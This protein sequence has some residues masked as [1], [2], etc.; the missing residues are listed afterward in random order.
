MHHRSI[1]AGSVVLCLLCS[2]GLEAQQSDSSVSNN[3]NLPASSQSAAGTVPG[4]IK[5]TGAVKDLTGKV[6]TGVAGLTFSLYELPEG[7]SPLWVETQSLPLD[8]L[9]R[10]AAL[11]GA[12]SPGGLPLDLF[13]T[14]KALWV[15]VQAQLPGAVEQP[16]VLLV[17]VPY[18]LKAADAD[19]LGGKPAS[20]FATVEDQPFSA[21]ALGTVP[22]G[23]SSAQ[24]STRSGQTVASATS[25]SCASVTSD[26]AATAN[27]LAKFVSHCQIENSAVSESGGNV[28]VT[29]NLGLPGTT[30]RGAGVIKLGGAP[31]IHECCNNSGYSNTFI[32]LGAGNFSGT[33]TYNTGSG[34]HAL[35]ANTNGKFN[36]ASGFYALSSNTTGTDNTANGGD[37]LGYNTTG[38]GNTASGRD[39][40]GRN[41][42]GNFNTAS[43]YG[44]LSL[45]TTGDRNTASGY[46]ALWL[47]T[48]GNQN[49]ASG[50]QALSANTTGNHNTGSGYQ[51]LYANTTGGYNT[52]SGYQA[53]Y[54][55]TKGYWNTASGDW[56]LYSNTTGFGNTASGVAALQANTTGYGNMASGYQALYANTTGI[57]NTA[58]GVSALYANTTGQGNTAV[59]NLAGVGAAG[60][61]PST[62]SWSTFVGFA[63]TATVDGLTFATA[64]GSE[65][66]VGESNALVLGRP[67]T[68]VGIS[69]STPSNIFTI[70][71]GFGHA[72]ADGWDTYSSRRWKSDIQP[73]RGALGKVERLRGVSYTYTANGKHDI[74]MIAEEVG[75][76]VPEVVSYE[77]NGKDARGIDYARLTALLVEAVKQQQDEIQQEKTQIRRLEAKV[78]RLETSKADAVQPGGKPAKPASAKAGK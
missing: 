16:R 45:N 22:A 20:A 69:T 55:N 30:L 76:V 58:S 51:A 65:A 12:S 72:I 47:N 77:E 67:G 35:S 54:S 17:A 49:T 1:L 38:S 4:L 19:T 3:T 64:I 73:L 62:G 29:G 53:L 7:G 71:Q 27:S 24:G 28:Q 9:G 78:R 15:G 37:A 44:A 13:T 60:T 39:A 42:I 25:G 10:Y 56:A 21:T 40:L 74:G 68:L 70:G 18:A 41:T 6:P 50:Y 14:R 43:G 11:L 63:A 48:T 31:F 5:F 33:G 75:K 59:G 36:T 61:L 66:Q 2:T 57:Y 23:A 52:A 8:S 32:G 46:Y 26:G 34:F